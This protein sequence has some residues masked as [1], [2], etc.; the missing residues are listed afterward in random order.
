MSK[1]APSILKQRYL[2]ERR[3][4]YLEREN[5]RQ[6]TKDS[7]GE[8]DSFVRYEDLKQPPQ[9]RRFARRDG[10]LYNIAVSFA[11]FAAAGFI[12]YLLGFPLLMRWA[13]LWAIA[14]V[15]FYGFYLYRRRDY[16]LVDLENGKAMV[17]LTNNQSKQELESFLEEMGEARKRY[18]RRK[19]FQILDPELPQREMARFEWL[20]KEGIISKPELEDM[21]EALMKE[22]KDTQQGE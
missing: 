15:I 6:F 18:L 9:M 4:H 5:I 2:N 13:P 11:L 10:R 19:Y 14:A 17:F 8:I 20:L 22:W 12:A 3:E 21:R 7:S 16:L 1:S